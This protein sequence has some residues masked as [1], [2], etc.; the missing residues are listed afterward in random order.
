MNPCPCGWLGDTSGKCRCTPEQVLRYRG[1]ISGPLLDRIDL[2]LFMPR[3]EAAQLGRDA[4]VSESSAAVRER[5]MAARQIQLERQG[6]TNAQLQGKA[7]GRNAQPDIEAEALLQTALSRQL[8]TA[9]SY[10]R[11]L[12]VARTLADLDSC[13]RLS[14]NHAAEALSYR[15]LDR[16]P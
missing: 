9:R 5:V 8:L 12:R 2:Q 11:C 10:H 3:V 1:K 4:Q 15:E 14:V 6:V 16:A 13:E 7:L